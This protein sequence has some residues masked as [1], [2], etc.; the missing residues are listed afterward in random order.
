MTLGLV[1][2]HD[3]KAP[4]DAETV[5]LLRKAGA[6]PVT[7]TNVPV[8]CMWWESANQ[9]FGMTKNPY[10]HT[11]TVGGSSGKIFFTLMS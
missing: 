11:R 9:A 6:I 3:R 4:S 2:H 5:T 10:N 1:M 7:V 8:F